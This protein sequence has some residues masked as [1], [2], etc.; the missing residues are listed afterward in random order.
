[1]PWGVG[2]AERRVSRVLPACAASLRH[3]PG[4][5]RSEAMMRRLL[6]LVMG[7]ALASAGLMG[8]SRQDADTAANRTEEAGETVARGAEDAGEAA[9]GAAEKAADRIGKAVESVGSAVTNQG[10]EAKIKNAINLS[11]QIRNK[12]T[13]IN[14]EVSDDQ[15]KLMGTVPT[16]KE[17][18][19]AEKL[20]RAEAGERKVLNQLQTTSD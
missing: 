12:A 15:V 8:C 20:A 2:G 16:R 3:R 14:V 13:K 6:L 4:W 18:Q 10:V 9:T 19:A 11:P 1:M 7:L 5:L 17:S